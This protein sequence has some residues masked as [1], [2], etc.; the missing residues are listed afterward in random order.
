[1]RIQ[2]DSHTLEGALERG[3]TEEEIKDVIETGVTIPAK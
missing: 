3:A 2:L 1:M